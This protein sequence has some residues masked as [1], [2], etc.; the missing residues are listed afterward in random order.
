MPN[1]VESKLNPEEALLR[2]EK[3]L[4]DIRFA[5]DES[6]I[7]AITDQRG[8]I[9]YVNQ[10]FCE[11]SKYSREELLGQDHRIIN[12]GYHPKE[13][14]RNLWT[15][16][17]SGKV[18]RGELRNRAK[19]GSL[20]WVDTTIVPFLNAEGKPYQYVAIRSDIT[21]RKRA[22]EQIREQAEL[23][24]Q[25]QDAILVRDLDQNIMFWNKGAE[26]I[27]GWTAE[28]VIGK[29]AE[30]LLFK[31][32]PR[33]LD[34]ARQAIIQNGEWKGEV[35]Q[36]Q[37]DGVEIV[38]ESRWT[39]VRD[40]QGRPKS[41][42]VIN[43]DVTEKR[44]M[45]SQFLRAQ[46]MESIGTL[47]GGIAHDL[48]NVLS[49][50]LMA[51]DMLQLKTTD[52]SSKKW[53][54]VLR[55]NAERGGNMVRQVLSF[56]RGVEGERLALQP[57]HLIKEI[58][59]ILRETLPKSIEINFHVPNDLWMISADAT[60]MHQV[61]MNLCVNARDAMPEGGSISI[62]AENVSV[63]ENYARMHI[64]A[65]AGRFVVINVADTGPG[66]SPDIQSRIFEP[67]F[68]TKE[69]TKGTGLGLSTAMTI[70]KSHGGFIN[71]YS[72]LHKG[73]QFAVYLPALAMPGAVDAAAARTDL[74]L[75]HGELI[76][77]VDDEESIREITRATLETF[78][79]TVLTASDGTEALAL[80]ADKK[81]EIAVVLTDMVMP[82]MDGPATIRALQRMN[83][84]VKII[85]ASGLGIGQ[86][87]GEGVLEGVSVFLNKPYT[88]E[89]LL[90]TLAAV[91]QS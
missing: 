4:A 20:Y 6:A 31:D 77:V 23:L 65:K 85:A 47:A 76:L 18:W 83:P 60:Q 39:L 46:R 43:T 63:D 11:I 24:D 88:A 25:A 87:A 26:K 70:V 68:T 19:D 48:N 50:I 16:I 79:Y 45:E 44:R 59:K 42:L 74:P 71:V 62:R 8:I 53:L 5:L 84:K 54:D 81:N 10:K 9:N 69:M 61:L 56:A 22:E 75:G 12:S 17:A 67:F 80:Y 21:E 78:G 86:R 7:V 41:I 27:Y 14:I 64:E 90:K 72:E 91:V 38:V 89:K 34:V 82:F 30:E 37:R 55:A 36:T 58:V 57:K 29:N 28:E 35:R 52:E 33:Q 66:M 51:I 49:P 32:R 40:E 3:E 73:S 2:S 1:S 15:T 13:F